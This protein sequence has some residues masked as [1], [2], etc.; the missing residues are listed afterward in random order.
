[1]NTK[2]LNVKQSTPM[3]AQYTEIKKQHPDSLLFFR[4][5]DFYE[6]FCEDAEI[7]SKELGLVLTKRVDLPMCGIP[8]H[9]YEMYVTRLING[10]HKVAICEQ[11]ESP[12]EAKKRGG[13]TTI[14]RGVTRII[15]RGTIV[16]SSLLTDKQSSFL[17]SVV[18]TGKKIGIAYSD[19]SIGNF[20]VESIDTQDLL[21]NI[22]RI[23]P[24][25]IICA[26]NILTSHIALDVMQKFKSIIYP[27]SSDRF[28]LDSCKKRLT[29]FYG[30]KFIDAFGVLPSEC[31]VAA[32]LILEYV[33]NAHVN[34]DIKLDFPKFENSE[35]YMQIDHFTRKSL[36]LHQSIHGDKKSSLFY[37]IDKTLTAQG[38]RLLSEWLANPLS[39]IKKIQK[40]LNFVEFFFDNRDFLS[41]LRSAID[42]LPD[43]ERAISRIYM[44][45]GGPRDLSAV[46]TAL[47][48]ITRLIHFVRTR[49]EL[50][51][52]DSDITVFKEITAELKESLSESDLPVSAN[53]GNFIVNGYDM[54]L[55]ECRNLVR[56]GGYIIQSLQKRYVEE[57]GI[58]NLKIKQNGVLGYFIETT[59]NNTSK[60]P[61][62]FIHRQTLASCIRYTTPELSTIAN[63]I[64]TGEGEAKRRELIIFE[65]LCEKIRFLYDSIKEVSQKISFI[66]CVS[67]LAVLAVEHKYVRPIMVGDLVLSIK[68]GRH[69]VVEQNMI[70]D[71]EK[72]TSNDCEIDKKSII[73]IVTGP[74]MGGKSTYLRQNAIIIIMAQIGSYVPSSEA[75]IGVV[76]KIFSRVGASDDISSGKSTFMV[77]MIETSV[78]L[79]QATEK[80][81]VILDEIGRGTSTY[82][83]LSIAWAVVEEI[84]NNI[85]SRTLFA[86]HYHELRQIANNIQNVKFLTVSVSESGGNIA[87]LHKIK[88]G[89]ADKSYGIHVA[90]LSGF[91]TR[92]V[93]RAEEVLK[94]ISKN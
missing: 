16:E 42:N 65:K 87:F 49:E 37:T 2:D 39:D 59:A 44:N 36:E 57:T 64:Y 62:E 33:N 80:S 77:E 86:T 32:A 40:R 52:L 81:F 55:D 61:Y 26:D 20:R 13:K 69:P 3:I 7:A 21:T 11:L 22:T 88:D 51:S 45:R 24:A 4:L 94:N 93:D 43:I 34:A 10:G 28:S 38:S 63:K 73:S 75:V 5:G 54:E 66:D 76:D 1:M 46:K 6:L 9:A 58:A 90:M 92:V 25:E 83:G 60:V 19:I 79:R 50:S 47:E 12:E 71:G 35:N 14:R 29:N 91:P 74:N 67:A 78:I 15:S 84:H 85:R 30:V 48:K 89:F 68:G 31:V 72:F 70:K 27:I 82:D 8:H 56:N 23:N 17:M 41:K 18:M 53:D